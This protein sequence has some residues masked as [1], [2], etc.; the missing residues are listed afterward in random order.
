LLGISFGLLLSSK[1]IAVAFC[2]GELVAIVALCR[3][4]DPKLQIDA[5]WALLTALFAFAVTN[6]AIATDAR[7][8]I[9]GVTNE[10]KHATIGTG[11]SGEVSWPIY[12][13]FYL[14]A[15]NDAL[16]P[17]GVGAVVCIFAVFFLC[18]HS[19]NPAVKALAVIL[20]AGSLVYFAFIQAAPLIG[21]VRYIHPVVWVISFL[22]V[23]M[24]A[25]LIRCECAKIKTFVI[26]ALAL[27]FVSQGVVHYTAYKALST[28]TYSQLYRWL[29]ESRRLESRILA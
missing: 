18:R 15:I 9:D 21:L 10:L 14:H 27:L 4:S 17:W 20:C 16:S 8:F 13:P 1:Y 25:E 2:L 7:A 23:L 3:A 12:S 26:T 19:A 24:A 6:N 22:A 28:P 29:I 5:R 11:E